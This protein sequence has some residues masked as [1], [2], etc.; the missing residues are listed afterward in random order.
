MVAFG[1]ESRPVLEIPVSEANT[2]DLIQVRPEDLGD[3]ID[4]RPLFGNDHPVEIEI[5]TG[6]G[7]FLILAARAHPEISYLGMDYSRKYLAVARRRVGRRGLANVRLLHTEAQCLL[8]RI[9]DG[10]VRVYHVYFPDPWPKKKHHKRRLFRAPFLQEAHRTLAPAGRILLLTD[11]ADYFL[12]IREAVDESGLFLT[13]EGGFPPEA[14]LDEDGV[15]NFEVKYR[16]E[17]RPIHRLA[18]RRRD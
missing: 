2:E 1:I 11:H 9:P 17:G 6:K 3:P 18:F 15:S 13:E 5:G 8:P 16:R 14:V 7:R 4:W 12:A 10:S